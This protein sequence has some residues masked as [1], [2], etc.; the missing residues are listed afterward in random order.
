MQ[1][2]KEL[3]AKM[4]Q[5]FEDVSDNKITLVKANTLTKVANVVISNERNKIASDRIDGVPNPPFY[6]D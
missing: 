3:T 6:R 2:Y 1:N 5:L 4:L